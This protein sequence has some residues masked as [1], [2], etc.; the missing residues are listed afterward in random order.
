MPF[1]EDDFD[2]SREVELYDWLRFK[3]GEKFP[4]LENHPDRMFS[5]E[6]VPGVEVRFFCITSKDGLYDTITCRQRR[7]I[8]SHYFFVFRMSI[9]YHLIK[10]SPSFRRFSRDDTEMIALNP[11]CTIGHGDLK[12]WFWNTSFIDI[13]FWWYC[14]SIKNSLKKF[15]SYLPTE[16]PVCLMETTFLCPIRMVRIMS[17]REES[18]G[19]TQGWFTRTIV[20]DDELEILRKSQR[21]LLMIFEMIE[22]KLHTSSTQRTVWI[23][24][25][26]WHFSAIYFHPFRYRV[27]SIFRYKKVWSIL[28]EMIF[29]LS[30]SGECRCSSWDQMFL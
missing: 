10:E 21:F 30:S 28:T 14:F 17:I 7:P 25:F 5:E 23:Q 3:P 15:F 12:F 8:V 11:E 29:H 20:T 13:P 16:C 9:S 6:G 2:R 26:L 4:S 1:F 19:F 24:L 22:M 18:E 27:R